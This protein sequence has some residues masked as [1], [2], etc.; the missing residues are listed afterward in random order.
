[1][2]IGDKCIGDSKVV[3][4]E[5]KL[6]GPAGIGFHVPAHADSAG[7]A[8]KHGCAHSANAMVLILYPVDHIHKRLGDFHLLGVHAVLG[9]IL[10]VNFA[11]VAETAMHCQECLMDAFDFHS[12]EE[13]AAEVHSCCRSNDSTFALGIN[14]L[15]T[16][17]I[18]RNGL[19]VDV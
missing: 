17:S 15:V 10:N 14:G 11:E 8:P 9:E 18:F 3:G 6:V 19:T 13:L 1:M 5:D 7:N 4:R 16:L 12:L 2:E